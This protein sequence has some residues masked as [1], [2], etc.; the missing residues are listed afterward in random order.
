MYM[1]MDDIH[2]NFDIHSREQATREDQARPQK[3]SLWPY[4]GD[5]QAVQD[6][7]VYRQLL[8]ELLEQGIRPRVGQELPLEDPLA[9]YKNIPLHARFLYTSMDPLVGS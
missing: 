1:G 9:R 4:I 5:W 6:G 7:T 8:R 3:D 2:D